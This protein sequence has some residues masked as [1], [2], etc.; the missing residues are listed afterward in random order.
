[1]YADDDVNFII[2]GDLNF[3]YKYDESL[4]S[5]P[6]HFI[7]NLFVCKQVIETPT[8]VTAT[9]TSLLDV[10]LTNAHDNHVQEAQGP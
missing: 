2:M 6:V 5:N 8:R 3:D 1:M 10:I 9:T 7:E 4:S